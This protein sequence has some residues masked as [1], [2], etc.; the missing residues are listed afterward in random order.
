MLKENDLEDAIK[1]V[2]E[3]KLDKEA[4]WA[5]DDGKIKEVLGVEVYGKRK[6][7]LNVMT[8][9]KRLHKEEFDKK[10]KIDK[11]FQIDTKEIRKLIEQA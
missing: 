4:F 3:N 5:L 1:K 6:N 7:L 10:L 2:E 9:I 11:D 8:E